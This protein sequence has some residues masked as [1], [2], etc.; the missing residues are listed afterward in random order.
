MEN[1]NHTLPLGKH[2]K[3]DWCSTSSGH[4]KSSTPDFC[5][6]FRSLF[7]FKYAFKGRKAA[8]EYCLAI[9]CRI[10]KTI[11]KNRK[12]ERLSAI[13]PRNLFDIIISLNVVKEFETKNIQLV[14][15]L[16]LENKCSHHLFFYFI[17]SSFNRESNTQIRFRAH[18][19][20][21]HKTKPHMLMSNCEFSTALSVFLTVQ[22]R[23]QKAQW[24]IEKCLPKSK[25]SV[26]KFSAKNT[27][28]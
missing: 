20:S 7:F 14:A 17:R 10:R 12:R 19:G 9:S 21:H 11:F 28:D 16:F 15:L 18:Y 8:L 4:F 27:M 25:Q 1:H 5:R 13:R 23:H 6:V 22:H 3:E 24:D 26:K 2:V